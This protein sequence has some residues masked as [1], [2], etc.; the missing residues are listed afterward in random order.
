MRTRPL[1]LASLMLIAFAAAV[2]VFAL[3]RPV[4][5]LRVSVSFI[6][7]TNDAK[8]GRLAMF[9]V[10]NHG[11]ATIFR[12]DHYHPE[13]Q[14]QP[15]L[16]S[17]LYIGLYPGPKVLLAP[18][19]S[20]VIAVPPPTNQ[21]VWRAG[22]DFGHDGW[23]RKFSDWRGPWRDGGLDAIVPDRLKG[24]PTQ[25]IRSDWIDP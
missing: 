20:E 15:G 8:A 19:Q 25:Q 11:D 17:T 16:L 12:W 9:A 7:Y 6:G 21:G 1:I 18:E 10:T 22:F 4:S 14:R 3:A 2:F 13:S 23:R 5:A 24:V